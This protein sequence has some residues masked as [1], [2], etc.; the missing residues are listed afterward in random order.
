MAQYETYE[1][2]RFW[3]DQ[4]NEDTLPRVLLVGD[5]ITAQYGGEVNTHLQ[6]IAHADYL[7][8]SKALDHPWYIR[9]LELCASQFDACYAA[10]HFNNGLHGAHLTPSAYES[11]LE[12][13]VCWLIDRFPQAKL[14]LA[15]CTPLVLAEEGRPLDPQKNAMVLARNE[16]IRRVAGRHNLPVNDLYT[17]MLN[18]PEWRNEGDAYHFAEGGRAVQS[19]LVAAAIRRLLG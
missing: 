6:G 3:Y 1:W 8:S 4:V 13:K 16:A 7:A 2:T 9:E 11:L 14:M 15:L 10:I 17:P 12:E 18:H 5:S 19:H